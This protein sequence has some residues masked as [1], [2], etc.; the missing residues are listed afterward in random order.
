MTIDKKVC[1]SVYPV[2][3]VYCTSFCQFIP[4]LVAERAKFTLHSVLTPLSILDLFGPTLIF[5]IS[6][7]SYIQFHFISFNSYFFISSLK[8][9]VDEILEFD[10]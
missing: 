2:Y 1:V 10:K 4:G 8:R 7:H 3:C 5:D 9:I 6:K